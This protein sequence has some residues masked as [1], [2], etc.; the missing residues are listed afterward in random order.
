MTLKLSAPG[1][2]HR[3][4]PTPVM[5]THLMNLVTLPDEENQVDSK[6]YLRNA[7]GHLN[8]IQVDR[9]V[10]KEEMEELQDMEIEIER[11]KKNYGNEV[12]YLTALL[13][14]MKTRFY[15]VLISFLVAISVCIL[16]YLY[17]G[18]L[19]NNEIIF[20]S[21][22]TFLFISL[23]VSIVFSS[24]FFGVNKRDYF[25][26]DASVEK[27]FEPKQEEEEEEEAETV[28]GSQTLIAQQNKVVQMYLSEVHPLIKRTEVLENNRTFFF[29]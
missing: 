13:D 24:E 1:W 11:Q 8:V 2:K 26:N 10:N 27:E 23:L 5:L 9:T 25:R 28:Y 19:P 22:L 14:S 20:G 29:S 6:N 17:M 15:N 16:H 21:I 7:I 4:Y 12:A 3:K 18:T